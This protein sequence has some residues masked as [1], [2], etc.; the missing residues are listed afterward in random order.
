M[1]REKFSNAFYISSAWRK[2]RDAYI[3][4][5]G[6]LC[7]ECQEKGLIV[8]GTQVHHKQKLTPENINNPA[9]SLN[10]DNLI[11]LC[12]KCHEAKHTRRK[13]TN[14]RWTVDDSGHV[15]I[16]DRE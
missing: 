14:R 7:E 5:V 8:P 4:S 13:D 9:V 2:C 16:L 12:D 3:Q 1:K 15:E 6:G 10:Y 11:L